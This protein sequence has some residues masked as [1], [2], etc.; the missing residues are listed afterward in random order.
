MRPK[1]IWNKWAMA[2]KMMK[3]NLSARDLE[4]LH[5]KM[6]LYHNTKLA[7]DDCRYKWRITIKLLVDIIDGQMSRVWRAGPKHG[8]FNSAG[9]GPAR[10]P[11]RA[12]AA[13]SARS[14]GLARHDY[15]F[16]VL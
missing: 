15:I 12:W 6:A 16:F 10:D 4:N 2:Q 9:P 8:P 11:C 13:A 1:N 5:N 7:P 3:S 14:A